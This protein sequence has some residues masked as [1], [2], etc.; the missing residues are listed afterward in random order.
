[1]K[2]SLHNIKKT[3]DPFISLSQKRTNELL[4]SLQYDYIDYK[5][6]EYAKRHK[7]PKLS[8]NEKFEI[9]NYWAQYG[10][11]IHNFDEFSRYYH[12]NGIRDPRYLTFPF[13][14]LVVYPYYNDL[15]IAKTWADK[16]AFE[17]FVPGMPFPI[18]LAQCINEKLFDA[19]HN[20]YGKTINDDFISAV[21]DDI[22]SR[23]LENIIIKKTIG[24]SAGRGVKK[25]Q[26]AT[27]E[28]LKR[29]L[30]SNKMSNYIVQEVIQ[31][32]EFFSQFNDSSVNII[33]INTWHNKNDVVIFSPCIRFGL[34]GSNTDVSYVNGEE[35]IMAAGVNND[36]TVGDFYC[37]NTGE[38]KPLMIENRKIPKWDKLCEL[39]KKNHKSLDYFDVVAWDMIVDANENVICIEYNIQQPGSIVYQC[40]H[41][42]F[43]G[44]Y[45]DE[46][47]SFLKYKNNQKKYIPKCI[48]I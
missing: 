40:I 18:M 12:I 34:K 7:I 1:M 22:K 46:F 10:V 16:N 21:Y 14:K 24:T 25:C 11:K 4:R 2:L 33:R 23:N 47:L 5:A 3:V 28:D 43:L 8:E 35:I 26:I 38:K 32:H 44:E 17:R 27:K 19:H 42:P 48:R 13:L 41:G 39:V 45:T 37:T 6:T 29:E 15:S 30:L 20:Y 36:G 31:Q 9:N